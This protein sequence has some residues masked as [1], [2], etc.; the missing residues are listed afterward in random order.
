MN[1]DGHRRNI[2]DC[3]FDELGVGHAEG[4]S[5]GRYWTQVFATRR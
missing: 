1:S 2:L 3:G 5:W 4:G